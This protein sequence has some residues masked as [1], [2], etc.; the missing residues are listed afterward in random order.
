[1]FYGVTDIATNVL[2][3]IIIVLLPAPNS[4]YVM[5]VASRRGVRAGYQGVCGVFGAKLADSTLN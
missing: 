4:L 2:G 1:M 3:T 5:T